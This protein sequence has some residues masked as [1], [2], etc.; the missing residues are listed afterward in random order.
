MNIIIA[1]GGKVGGTVAEHLSNEGH[2]VTI[3]DMSESTLN[4][5]GNQLDVMCLKGNCVSRDL[6]LEAGVRECDALIAA[7]GSDE[8][9]LLCCHCARNLGVP[10]TVARVRGTE[11]ANDL[12]SLKQDL[13]IS[14]LI[15]PELAAAVEISRLLRFPSAANIDTFA[16]GQVELVSFHIQEDDFL[17]GRSLASLSPKIQGLP[18]LFCAV[19]RGDSVFIPNGSTVLNKDDRVYL[20]GTPNGIHQFFKLLGRETHRIRDVF[21]IGGGRI[22]FYLLIQLERLGM[23]CKVVERSDARCRQL[24]EGFPHSLIIHGDGTD[25]ELL[26]EER[27]AASDAFIALTDR[28]EDNL[29]ISLYAH[30]AG[31]AKV[32][33]KSSR[34]NYTSIAHSAGVESV[35]SPKLTTAG[36][37]LRLVRGLQNSKGSAMTALYRIAEGR[38]EAMEFVVAPTT[39]HLGIPLKDLKLKKGILIAVIVRGTKVIIP[40]GSSTLER[41]DNVIVV[42]R[43]SGILDL[44]DIYDGSGLR[45]GG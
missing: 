9:N 2:S 14:M 5:L 27:M 16:R 17:A 7:T 34:Q 37:I 28:D 31:V 24:A 4:R 43:D 21:I 45:A 3:V 41:G 44:N 20:A 8:I 32:V 35:V 36:Q 13:G 39:Q 26:T 19:E 12:D 29:I 1:G 22:A 42:A 10:Y 6:L 25:P 11:Y 38:A 23:S 15:N 18:V 30:Q 33:A 40:E